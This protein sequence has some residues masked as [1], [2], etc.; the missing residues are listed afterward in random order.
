MSDRAPRTDPLLECDRRHWVL[1]RTASSTLSYTHIHHVQVPRVLLS[2]THTFI[3]AEWRIWSEI[4]YIWSLVKYFWRWYFIKT[5]RKSVLI[6]CHFYV[7]NLCISQTML[8]LVNLRIL[9]YSHTSSVFSLKKWAE[10]LCSCHTHVPK[11]K[12][13]YQPRAWASFYSNI[14]WI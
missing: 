7:H 5:W 4:V 10:E 9:L 6:L 1:P 14:L 8:Q 13:L 2:L 3:N 12:R 11:W